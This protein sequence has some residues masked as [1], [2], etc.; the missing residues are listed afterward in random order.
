MFERLR[1]TQS[2]KGSAGGVFDERD[3]LGEYLL[4]GLRPSFEVVEGRLF[5]GDRH[6]SRLSR[7]TSTRFAES[8]AFLIAVG[9]LERLEKVLCELIGFDPIGSLHVR[10]LSALLRIFYGRAGTTINRYTDGPRGR[11][12][13]ACLT[14]ARKSFGM[15][16]AGR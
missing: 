9:G 14:T 4:I 13:A 8:L 11:A 6:S 16:R 7:G 5:E 1:F 12:T 3:D 2:G 10:L 15:M